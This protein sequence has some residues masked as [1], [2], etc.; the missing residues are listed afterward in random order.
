MSRHDERKQDGG[1][2]TFVC[3]SMSHLYVLEAQ[4]DNHHHHTH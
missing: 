2:L 3:I 4:D 1:E